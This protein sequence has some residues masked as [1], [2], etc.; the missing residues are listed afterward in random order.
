MNGNSSMRIR[1]LYLMSGPM[2]NGGISNV[3]HD[4]CL[5]LDK[6]KYEI[7]V[8]S[9]GL[10][11]P[12]RASSLKSLGV[13]L[14]NLPY[15][16]DRFLVNFFGLF[17]FFLRQKVDV[18]H[19]HMDG[20]N[21]IGGFFASFF[22]IKNVIYHSHNTGLTNNSLSRRVS[23]KLFCILNCLGRD[24][25]RLACS[26]DAGKF[27]FPFSSF[28][29]IDN[30]IKIDEFIFNILTRQR[31]RA[32]YN[33]TNEDIVIGFL[34]RIDH[35]KNPFF[36]VDLAI[37]LSLISANYKI[38]IIGKGVLENKLKELICSSGIRN[39]LMIGEVNNANDYYNVMDL[40]IM[41]SIFEGLGLTFV[42]AQ[43]NGLMCL[44][45]NYL[46]VEAFFSPRAEAILLNVDDWCKRIVN[47]EFD[48]SDRSE[49]CSSILALSAR[50]DSKNVVKKLEEFYG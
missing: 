45:S 14:I 32:R 6:T 43:L 24:I 26:A 5:N 40:F 36:V 27:L 48:E 9:N 49:T 29:C 2:D 35:Q 19:C 50:F 25:K 16:K 11:L 39:V 21:F 8:I 33:F 12:D 17:K 47:I 18:V 22:N 20:A 7:F 15:R 34:G 4:Y 31:L 23:H 10:D 3:I 44:G 46:P 28:H 13:K 38:L 42:E 1:I 41:P 30:P 37:K